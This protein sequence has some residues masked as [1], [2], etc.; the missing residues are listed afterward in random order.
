MNDTRAPEMIRVAAEPT[1]HH[2]KAMLMTEG[3]AIASS[4]A[5]LSQ[6]GR[7]AQC[8]CRCTPIHAQAQPWLFSLNEH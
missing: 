4:Q 2:V 8:H 7:H 1:L 5:L 3:V 6:H